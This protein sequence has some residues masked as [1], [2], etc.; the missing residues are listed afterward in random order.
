MK[1]LHFI[2]LVLVLVL[3]VSCKMSYA[4]SKETVTLNQ[5][6][7]TLNLPVG[8]DILIV[9]ANQKLGYKFI[10]KD[11]TTVYIH[12]DDVN[13]NLIRIR[14]LGDSIIFE[15][16]EKLDFSFLG[17]EY[18]IKDTIDLS[19]LDSSSGLYFRDLKINE[20]GYGYFNV[21]SEDKELFDKII[22]S[23]LRGS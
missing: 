21:K 16:F 20:I 14:S 11:S 18:G 8:Y 15:R 22:D 10:Y 5:K 7:Y 19:G 9:S 17:K 3:V 23:K 12:L 6:D 2:I 4:F 1:N 13:P